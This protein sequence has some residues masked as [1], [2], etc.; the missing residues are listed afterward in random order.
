MASHRRLIQLTSLIH[1]NV[2]QVDG[3]IESNGLPEPSFE[4]SC[5]P[6]LALSPE[7][8]IARKRALEALDELRQHLLGPVHAVLDEMM[9]VR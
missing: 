1:E 7:A 4:A 6:I 9:Q 5:P 2:A 8:D 3:F